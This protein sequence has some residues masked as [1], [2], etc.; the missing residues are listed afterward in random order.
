MSNPFARVDEFFFD[1]E[2]RHACEEG[3]LA[4]DLLA[5]VGANV[6]DDRWGKGTIVKIEDRGVT[7]Q[8]T[9]KFSMFGLKLIPVRKLNVVD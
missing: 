5:K 2:W 4:T 1:G 3:A 9:V 6:H 7:R 8:A